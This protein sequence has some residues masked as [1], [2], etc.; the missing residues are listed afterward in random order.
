M[1]LEDIVKIRKNF[2]DQPD[3]KPV[4]Q[5]PMDPKLDLAAYPWDQCIADQMERYGDEEIAKKVCGAIK[6]MYGSK[7]KMNIEPNPCW[8]GYEPIGLKDDGS[9]NCVPIKQSKEE[10]V[11]PS[12]ES[13]EDQDTFIGRCVPAIIDEYGKEVAL[14]IC[15]SQWTKK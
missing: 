8:E 11:I 6:A 14:G 7:E 2:Q 9:P 10:F 1:K 5:D 13:N 3:E 15:Y 4:Q 12:P